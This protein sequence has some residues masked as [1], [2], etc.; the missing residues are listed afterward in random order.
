[1]LT[2]LDPEEKPVVSSPSPAP[3]P[4]HTRTHTSPVQAGRVEGNVDVGRRIA[5]ALSSV[6]M[7][8]ADLLGADFKAAV[9]EVAMVSGSPLLRPCRFPW[10]F[11]LRV[12]CMRV[13]VC[14]CMYLLVHLTQH[15][16]CLPRSEHSS[17]SPPFPPI[18]MFTLCVA[19]GPRCQVGPG[20]GCGGR[21]G[22]AVV[23]AWKGCIGAFGTLGASAAVLAPLPSVLPK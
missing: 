4:A 12:M 21:Q 8:G 22:S 16:V 13:C 20:R 2:Y 10:A 1:V 3:P 19:G 14:A 11:C 17:P 18:P 5:H 15:V 9:H 6:P 23:P 7:P